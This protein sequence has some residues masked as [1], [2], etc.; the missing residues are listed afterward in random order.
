ML[1]RLISL[2]L[3]MV[4][5]LSSVSAAEPPSL[6]M[7]LKLVGSNNYFGYRYATHN[8]NDDLASFRQEVCRRTIEELHDRAL[9]STLCWP[10]HHDARPG[11]AGTLQVMLIEQPDDWLMNLQLVTEE[12]GPELLAESGLWQT[13]FIPNNSGPPGDELHHAIVERLR[14]QLLE[15]D[16]LAEFKSRLARNIP[17]GAGVYRPTTDIPDTIGFLESDHRT[18]RGWKVPFE[19]EFP[20]SQFRNERIKVVGSGSVYETT[21]SGGM[22]ETWIVIEF[23]SPPPPPQTI[24]RVYLDSADISGGSIPLN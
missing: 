16:S 8:R 21:N 20:V 18:L 23:P 6:Q 22:K 1:L 17:V 10:L 14:V 24:G 15:L 11:Q 19:F 13:G 7:T 4:S 5:A 2:L 9:W 3:L 12:N